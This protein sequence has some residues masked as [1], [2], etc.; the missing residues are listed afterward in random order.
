MNSDVRSFQGLLAGDQF[1]EDRQ[2]LLAVKVG[3][4]EFLPYGLLI[5]MAEH[6]LVQELPG[7]VDIAAQ[8]F[9]G[10]PPQEQPIE[11]GRLALRRQ[12]IELFQLPRHRH[13]NVIIIAGRVLRK[14]PKVPPYAFSRRFLTQGLCH[15]FTLCARFGP[16]WRAFGEEE[17]ISRNKET[18][19][20][21]AI[22][23][24]INI[25]DPISVNSFPLARVLPDP[26]LINT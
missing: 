25:G 17:T 8:G 16:S 14:T 9:G 4:L 3:A 21:P 5:A 11:Q 6:Q 22:T 19:S 20:N 18:I 10:V 7:D 2:D 15:Y 24:P 12:G 23:A 13:K 1:V 26:T